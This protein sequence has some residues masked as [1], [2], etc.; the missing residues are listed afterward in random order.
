[1]GKKKTADKS[2]ANVEL[3]EVHRTGEGL[4]NALFDEI[5]LMRSGKGDRRRA[6]AIAA[7][8]GRIVDTVKIEI[9]YAK[10]VSLAAKDVGEE[11]AIG[12]LRLGRDTV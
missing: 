8:A 3:P 11:G 9:E 2:P 4:R 1:M 5:D 7:L 12:T 10:Q 6:V